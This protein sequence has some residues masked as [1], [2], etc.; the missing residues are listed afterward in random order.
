MAPDGRRLLSGSDDT[1]GLLW[2][3]TLAGAAKPRKEP[4]TAAGADGLWVALAG[5]EAQPAYAAMA[6][7]AAAPALAVALVRRE[8]KPAPAAPTDAELDRTFADLDSK[9]FATREKASR[10]L[11]EW[12]EWAVPGVRKR[13][14]KTASAEVRRRA[15]EFLDRFDTPKPSPDR[16]RQLRAVELLEGIATPAARDVLSELAKGAAEAP[17]SREAAAALERLRR[18]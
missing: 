10:R 16:L 8:L 5:P 11:A 4:L 17:L 2:D 3:T 13:F 6:D 7:L 18:R 1:F 15:Q 9:V 14:V 12:G